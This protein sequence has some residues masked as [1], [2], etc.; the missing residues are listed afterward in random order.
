MPT[1][2]AG[3]PD[4]VVAGPEATGQQPAADPEELA[5]LLQTAAGGLEDRDRTVL[6][7]NVVQGLEGQE[8]ADALGV[9]LDHAY[10]LTHR[11]KE[12]LERSTS[13]LLVVSAGRSVCEDLDG[14][15]ANWDGNYD[16]L[17]R[18]RFAR[19][20][21]RCER[22]QRMKRRLPKAVLSGAALSQAAQ[23]AVLAAPISVRKAVLEQAPTLVASSQQRPWSRDGFPG[24]MRSRRG[25][26][27]VLAGCLAAVL[28]VLGTGSLVGGSWKDTP[29]V[30]DP[31][32]R[33][34][35]VREVPAVGGQPGPASPSAPVGAGGVSGPDAPPFS[36]PEATG[37]RAGG[38]DGTGPQTPDTGAASCPSSLRWLRA[39]PI[40]VPVRPRRD[41]LLRTA[42]GW[43][44]RADDRRN[45]P[46]C[47]LRAG[48]CGRGRQRCAGSGHRPQEPAGDL[49]S[50]HLRRPPGAAPHHHAAGVRLSD[51]ARRGAPARPR[52]AERN[53]KRVLARSL[54]WRCDA[55]DQ[56]VATSDVRATSRTGEKGNT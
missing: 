50:S 56:H 33:D 7:L 28:L 55:D 17:W 12:R 22:C 6:E 34:E 53:L 25:A 8:L 24:G 29:A 21:E 9:K 37:N 23:A 14:V 39:I 42:H 3:G 36:D 38:D 10:Q 54:V 16:V 44:E 26:A 11:M 31:A 49:G 13:A 18:K 15:A 45:R 1:L 43:P 41:R 5:E 46:G 51:S 19:H 2:A 35:T 48:R 47:H 30:S 27:R 20:V 32:P 40:P 4:M 52:R